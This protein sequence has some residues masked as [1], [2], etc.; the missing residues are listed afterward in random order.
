MQT[1]TARL[2]VHP[3]KGILASDERIS[4]LNKKFTSLGIPPTAE[5]RRAYR[6]LFIC[7]D[8]LEN[9]I[10]GII[11]AE[12]T[13]QQTASNGLGFTEI[14][15]QKG[16]LIGVKVDLGTTNLPGFPQEKYTEGLDQLAVK[17]RVF[18]S[19][20]ASFTK[21]RSV[22]SIGDGIPSPQAIA[23]NSNLLALYASIVQQAGLVP[24][25]EPEVLMNGQHSAEK[26]G[27]VSTE[28]LLSL[29]RELDFLRVNREQ[30]ILKTNMILPS[31]GQPST[32]AE[33]AQLTVQVLKQTVPN[34]V[35]GIVFL[36]GGQTPDQATANLNAIA[37]LEPLP[38][39]I[40][41][42]FLRALEQ[43]ALETWRGDNSK[44]PEAR[45]VFKECLAKEVAAE[46]G[47]TTLTSATKY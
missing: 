17:V 16:I 38:W 27:E 43:P 42:S 5:M 6:Q 44:Y 30:I 26:C 34:D 47:Q 14:L 36:S 20:G 37:Q 8:G 9:Y 11:L 28:I 10:N 19:L 21:W 2:L 41:F 33:T 4:S 12:D 35:P 25:L 46:L 7:T 18:K 3:G 15:K 40:S 32:P 23:V 24:I 29:F 31:N 22:Y 1:N 13:I 45:Q 39:Q